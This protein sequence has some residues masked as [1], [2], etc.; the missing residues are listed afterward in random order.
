[1]ASAGYGHTVYFHRCDLQVALWSA[2]VSVQNQ[3][4]KHMTV[5]KYTS[6]G[7]LRFPC[8]DTAE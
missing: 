5:M 7:L 6:H 2:L 3:L 4:A 1:M 8:P